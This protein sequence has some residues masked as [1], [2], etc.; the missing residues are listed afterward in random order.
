MKL[1]HTNLSKQIIFTENKINVITIE[2]RGFYTSLIKDLNAQLLSAGGDFVLSKNNKELKLN[3]ELDLVIDLFNLDLNSRKNITKVYKDLNSSAFNEENYQI[4][5]DF[6]ISLINYMDNLIHSYDLPLEYNLD[7]DLSGVFK[8]LN[9]VLESNSS[10]LLESILQY[11]EVSLKL[12]STSCFVFVN[13]KNFLSY[14]ELEQ[15]YKFVHY[16]KINILLLES[17]FE[18]KTNPCEIHYL[19]DKDLCEIY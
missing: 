10:N 7:F 1:I 11:I 4:T 6:K 5:N 12:L 3:S 14:E 13:L 19:I 17:H 15:L 9:L 2:N 8:T 16:N 18:E